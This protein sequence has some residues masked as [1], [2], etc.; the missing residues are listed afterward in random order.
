MAEGYVNEKNPNTKLKGQLSNYQP[1]SLCLYINYP[2]I[3]QDDRCQAQQLSSS[4]NQLWQQLLL[5]TWPCRHSSGAHLWSS[6]LRRPPDRQKNHTPWVHLESWEYEA[7]Q[8][9]TTNPIFWVI[10]L[11]HVYHYVMGENPAQKKDKTGVPGFTNVQCTVVSFLGRVSV[12]SLPQHRQ[13]RPQNL[14]SS[15]R[16]QTQDDYGDCLAT[17]SDHNPQ[18]VCARGNTW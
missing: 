11:S 4:I 13:W 16:T 7:E 2:T 5:S 12:S 14:N 18:H 8:S 15:T 17:M 10:S 3:N 9:G 1:T 6:W